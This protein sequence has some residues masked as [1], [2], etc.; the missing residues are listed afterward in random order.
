MKNFQLEI[1][2]GDENN[3]RNSFFENK[4]N[5]ELKKRESVDGQKLRIMKSELH[6][7]IDF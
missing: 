2:L 7:R 5:L 6:S 4:E 3:V 1:F